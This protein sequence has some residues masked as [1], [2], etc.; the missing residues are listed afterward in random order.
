[1]GERGQRRKGAKNAKRRGDGSEGP[2]RGRQRS[3]GQEQPLVKVERMASPPPCSQ[4]DK[5]ACWS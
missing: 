3:K 4:T 2:K 1:M 5:P